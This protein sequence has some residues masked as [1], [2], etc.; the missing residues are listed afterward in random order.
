MNKNLSTALQVCTA[1][2]LSCGRYTVDFVNHGYLLL[3]GGSMFGAVPRALWERKMAPDEKNR[4]RLATHSLLIRG[5]GRTIL[6]DV[7]CGEKWNEKQH[8]IFGFSPP[9]AGKKTIPFEEVTDV[10]ITHLHFDHAAGLTYT[11]PQGE[12]HLRYPDAKIWI[13]EENYTAATHPNVRERA[14]Y[15]S[16]HVAPLKDAKL[17]LLNGREEVFPDITV[18]VS[19]GHTRGL[20]RIKISGGEYPLHFPSDLMPTSHHLPLPYHM[21]FDMC[22]A[23][24]LEEKSEFLEEVISEGG[25]I[26]LQHDPEVLILR[27]ARSDSGRIEGTREL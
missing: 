8:A 5:E 10:I 16:N 21:G 17:Q 22:A 6:V 15:L 25:R 26:A 14:S 11:D 9:L 19:H 13:Q 1:E 7:G 12:L 4:I 3:D 27:V 20:Q 18:D 24:I 2:P 23:Q